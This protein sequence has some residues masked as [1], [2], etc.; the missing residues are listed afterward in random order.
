MYNFK[1]LDFRKRFLVLD[2]SK[3]DE[4]I[5]EELVKFWDWIHTRVT[6]GNWGV[7]D[8][9]GKRKLSFEFHK[10]ENSYRGAIHI[11]VFVTEHAPIPT[12]SH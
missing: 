9:S 1:E 8:D 7:S 6:D 4:M 3:Q 2:D 12:G 10:E 5:V 11:D